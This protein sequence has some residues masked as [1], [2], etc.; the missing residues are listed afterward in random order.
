MGY[1]IVTPVANFKPGIKGS[2][3]SAEDR[4][5]SSRHSLKVNVTAGRMVTDALRNASVEKIELANQNPNITSLTDQKS[6]SQNDK[7][8]P[9]GPAILKGHRLDFDEQD[10]EQGIFLINGTQIVKVSEVVKQ[11]P[12]EVIFMVPGELA[13]GDYELELKRKSNGSK[14]LR[15]YRVKKLKAV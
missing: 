3:N 4:F 14:T 13:Q 9:N 15:S 1:S 12:V 8:T 11:Q 2:F 5:D 10:E 6:K 7:L